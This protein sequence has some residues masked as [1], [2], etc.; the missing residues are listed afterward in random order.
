[1]PL[2]GGAGGYAQLVTASGERRSGQP[3]AKIPL[4]SRGARGVA[5]GTRN[6]FFEDATVAD[7]H[8]RIWTTQYAPGI[9]LQIARPLDEVDRTLDRL[10]GYLHR[11]RGRRDRAGGVARRAHLA[12]RRS[13]RC[14][15]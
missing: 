14:G 15:G 3:D 8:M 10:A 11:D 7:T 4:P 5:D 1:M 12:A 6:P 9:A 13:R 2:L